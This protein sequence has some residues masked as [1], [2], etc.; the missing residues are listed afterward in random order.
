MWTHLIELHF[1]IQGR[2][3]IGRNKRG[4]AR[5]LGCSHRQYFVDVSHALQGEPLWPSLDAEA[6]QG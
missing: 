1:Y 2:A 5:A 3:G 6:P 4:E